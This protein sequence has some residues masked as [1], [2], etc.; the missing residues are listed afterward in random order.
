MQR[1]AALALVAVSLAGPGAAEAR[2]AASADR[3]L[4][5]LL[6]A[7]VTE[8]SPGALVLVD[9]GA[10]RRAA[11]RGF[12]VLPTRAALRAGDRFRVGSITK[13]FVAVVALQLVAEGRLALRNTVERWL[14]GLVPNGDRITVEDLLG[15][16][17][18][19]A[20]YAGDAAF[21]RRTA[22]EPARRWA[23]RELVRVA[24]AQGP[25]AAPGKRFSYA[26][27]N[28][29]LLGLIVERATGTTLQQELHRRILSP[30][31]L[32]STSFAPGTQ[33]VGRR[34]H[35]Y[36]PSQHDGIVGSL[37]TA[38]DLDTASASWG[39]AAGAIV[40]TAP[41]LSRFLGALLQ[42]R[43]LPER[44]LAPMRPASGALYGLGLAAFRTPCGVA[45]GHTGNLLGTVSAAWSSPDGRRRVVAMSNSY[46][47]TGASSRYR[48]PS[49]PRRGVL[50]RPLDGPPRSRRSPR[51]RG[52]ARTGPAR[53]RGGR[54][55]PAR[56]RAGRPRVARR[57][58]PQTGSRGRSS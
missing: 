21:L 55:R 28:Y 37:A 53:G 44:L 52:R 6:G 1:I 27:T 43:L 32:T 25:V 47:P 38:R 51:R 8:G 29:V 35:G 9:D 45:I 39:W 40:S 46:L 15:H 20:D 10:S 19:L 26:S 58:S 57:P 14:P 31:R 49:A 22:R 18:G 24:L 48:A 23:P 13:T 12:A 34:A 5:Q 11:A 50:P 54:P 30:L 56:P 36:A 16:T 4:G 33:V 3:P 17:S 7:V 42:G 2:P 41:D